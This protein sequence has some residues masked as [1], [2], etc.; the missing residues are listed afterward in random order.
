MGYPLFVY[1]TLR[2]DRAP[3]D[4]AGTLGLLRPVGTAVLRGRLHDLGAYPGVTLPGDE[5]IQGQLFALPEDE[6]AVWPA[7][8]AYEDFWL[9]NPAGSL[10][11]RAAQQVSL[12]D[13]TSV[14]AWVY[15][16][17]R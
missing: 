4:L 14:M 2:P 8:D 13:G 11:V 9:E 3:A 12:A 15:L 5:E 16:Y 10:F 1:G 6:S 17:N 7:L